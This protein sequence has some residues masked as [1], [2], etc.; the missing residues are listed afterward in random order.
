MITPF[1]F[2]LYLISTEHQ[3]EGGRGYI[4]IYVQYIY[5]HLFAGD[6]YAYIKGVRAVGNH[7]YFNT[8][9][10][11]GQQT[12]IRRSMDQTFVL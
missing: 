9:V 11:T 4:P 6:G 5:I 3:M 12:R 1:E 7:F 10:E 8:S 2:F